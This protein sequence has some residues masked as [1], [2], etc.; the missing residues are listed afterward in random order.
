MPFPNT[1]N[2]TLTS[3]VAFGSQSVY[4]TARSGRIYRYDGTAW[5]IVFENSTISLNDI[6][7]TSPADLWAAGDN[8]QILHWP[9]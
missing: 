3:V 2:E 7:G 6:A 9:Q 5:Q 8:G 1:N 4:V